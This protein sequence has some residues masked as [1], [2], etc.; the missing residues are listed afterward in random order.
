MKT[1]NV[2]GRK[3]MLYSFVL[4]DKAQYHGQEAL[5]VTW[6]LPSGRRELL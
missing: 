4:E 2:T 5:F 3:G 6:A 1:A